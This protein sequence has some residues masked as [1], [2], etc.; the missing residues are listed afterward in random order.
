MNRY[1]GFKVLI[2][3]D[4]ANNLFALRTLIQK[5]MDVTVLEASSGKDAIDIAVREPDIDLII[6]DIQMPEMDGFQT[7]SMLKIRRKT[8]EI[9]DLR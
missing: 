2:V 5:H 9:E 3:D 7:A 6:L 8:R 1:A 4:N